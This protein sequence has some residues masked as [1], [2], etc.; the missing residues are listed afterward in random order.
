M[1]SPAS[2]GSPP[3]RWGP[4]GPA[5]ERDA[6]GIGFV[7][8][9]HGRPS[10]VIVDAALS[11]LA[12]VIHRGALA[13]D[14]AT[15]DGSGLLLPIPRSIFGAGHGVASLMV[16]GGADPRPAFE[17][18]ARAEG[19]TVEAWRRP[20]FDPDHL[21]ILARRSQPV[22][23]QA[24]LSRAEAGGEERAAWRLRRRVDHRPDLAGIYVVSCSWRTIVYKG[25]VAADRL[26]RFYPDLADPAVEAAF[27]VFHQ[28]FSTNTSPTWERTQPFRTLCHNGEIN[29]IT[30]N[31]AAMA[32]RGTLGTEVAGLSA[33]VLARPVLSA[34][35]SDSGMLDSAVELLVRGGRDVRHAVSM[36]VPPAWEGDMEMDPAV[37][38]FYRY[39]SALVEPWDGPAGMIFTDGVGVGAALDR[40]GLRPLRYAVCS[41]GLVAVCSEAGAVDVAGHG[42]VSRGRLGPGQMLFVSPDRA[43][44]LDG[45]CKE[46]L[47]AAGPYARWNAD[48][49]ISVD[50]GHPVIAAGDLED[51]LRRQRAHGFTVEEHRMITGPMAA[52][53]KEPTFA[54]GDDTALPSLSGRPRPLHHLLRQRFAQ[55]TNPPIDHLRE[56]TVMSL[57]T[58]LGP[59]QPLLSERPEAAR[60]VELDSIVVYPSRVAWLTDEF[61]GPFPAVTLDATFASMSGPPGLRAAIDDLADRAATAVDDG[62][63]VIVIDHGTLRADRAPIPS[64]LAVGA[65]HHRLGQLA[66]RPAASVVV[67]ADDVFDVH[68]LACLA[69]MGADAICPRLALETVAADADASDE[70]DMVAPEASERLRSAFEDGLLKILSKMGIATIASYR[71]AAL[72]E[73]IGLDREVTDRC[74]PGVPSVVGGLGWDHLGADVIANHNAAWSSPKPPELDNPGWIRDR[75]RGGDLHLHNKSVVDALHAQV[76]SAATAPSPSPGD[77]DLASARAAAHLLRRAIAG[78]SQ[79]QY[80]SFAATVNDRPPTAL[81]DLL[82]VIPA[83]DPVPVNEVEPVSSITQRFS[84]GAMS[85]GSLSAE[86]HETLA[87]AMNLIGGRSNCGEG[88]EDPSRFV[89]RGR[90]H[91]D[92]NSR[93]KQVAS[94]RFGVTPRYCAMAD[95]LQIKMA[96]GSK[97]GEGGQLPGHKVSDEI[98]RLRH[99]QP[100]VTL[101]SPPPITTSTPSRTWRSSSSTSARSTASPTFRSSWSASTGWARWHRVWSRPWPMSCT[102]AGRMAAPGRLPS[103]RSSTQGCPGSWAWPR[104]RPR[105]SPTTCAPGSG[106]G[107]TAA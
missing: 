72:L 63:G 59:R 75:K 43:V 48:G 55:V 97:P 26:S 93:I 68:A 80:D 44:L 25:L 71:G 20:P 3:P 16:R 58:L 37:R 54:M 98:G 84:T 2:F 76:A 33:E 40:N 4:H 21:G 102:S 74:F 15:A 101:I 10:R 65:V 12:R 69:G 107:S 11:A 34:A 87:A 105:W 61:T 95:E 31:V 57:R 41:D 100:G 22:L 96:Q 50:G 5:T 51:L 91:G 53:A 35:D 70:R 19:I 62:A 30:G 104:P 1:P 79:A 77:P 24:I 103:R 106:S 52:D 66:R 90:R 81:R 7:A 32:G 14:D 64:L 29:A 78:G 13:A 94:G 60:L 49:F 39:H 36:L 88:G 27:A 47:S 92:T 89:T 17:T 38:A 56:R 82:E 83:G 99:T 42:T 86:A 6:C 23:I 67:V 8:D 9:A 85:H 45:A 73:A 18:E 46:R 28:R